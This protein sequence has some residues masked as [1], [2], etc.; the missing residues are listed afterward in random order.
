[1]NLPATVPTA[2]WRGQQLGIAEVRQAGS[3]IATVPLLA[4]AAVSDPSEVRVVPKPKPAPVVEPE[5]NPWERVVRAATH[6]MGL[7]SVRLL[8]TSTEAR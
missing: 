4:E 3:V 8:G 1:M 5:A 2:V 7:V 6:S